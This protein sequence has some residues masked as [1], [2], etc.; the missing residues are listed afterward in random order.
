[1]THAVGLACG[2]PLRRRASPMPSWDALTKRVLP[3]RTAPSWRAR[4][5]TRSSRVLNR[6][7]ASRFPRAVAWQSRD[8]RGGRL[9]DLPS[10][11]DAM[12]FGIRG[13]VPVHADAIGGTHRRR[14]PL[15]LEVEAMVDG[16]AAA[17][18][19]SSTT[20]GIGD[21][22]AMPRSAPGGSARRSR[23]WAS[24]VPGGIAGSRSTP[25]PQ[26]LSAAAPC[27][28]SAPRCAARNDE[29]GAGRRWARRLRSSTPGRAL[30]AEQAGRR[31]SRAFPGASRRRELTET[32]RRVAELVAEGR[33]NREVAARFSSACGRSR[34]TS[35]G[36]TRS[37]ASDRAASWPAA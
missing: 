3:P 28:R 19:R 36:C 31:S 14:R 17:R 11:V 22:R 9:R 33:S 8:G 25:P 10:I 32:E 7:W 37:S 26:P 12:G 30:W 5:A 21:G 18:P 29:R 34:R 27:S 1:M 6:E 2:R 16:L 15:P 20:R 24:A 13:F 4:A 23:R 35:R